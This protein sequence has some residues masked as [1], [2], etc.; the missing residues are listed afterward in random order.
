M[1]HRDGQ[2]NQANKNKQRFQPSLRSFWRSSYLEP[3]ESDSQESIAPI[4]FKHRNCRARDRWPEKIRD[5]W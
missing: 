1:R 3:S 2:N 4:C 5:L